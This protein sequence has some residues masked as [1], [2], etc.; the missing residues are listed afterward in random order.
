M[1]WT[2]CAPLVFST[3]L[4]IIL[5]Y[6]PSSGQVQREWVGWSFYWHDKIGYQKLCFSNSQR[7]RLSVF[8]LYLDQRAFY[9]VKWNCKYSGKTY[10]LCPE[11]ACEEMLDG[12]QAMLNFLDIE[13]S[14]VYLW[15]TFLLLF[16]VF[17]WPS[18]VILYYP[19]VDDY[20]YGLITALLKCYLMKVG[21]LCKIS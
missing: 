18:N 19:G 20:T 2:I 8:L 5:A 10:H 21:N 17:K 7:D 11:S 3:S 12:W 1:L 4:L 9:L 13:D 6:C 15:F 14:S 16:L